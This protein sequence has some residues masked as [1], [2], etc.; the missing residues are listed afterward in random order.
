[1]MMFVSEDSHTQFDYFKNSNNFK[2]QT[3]RPTCRSCKQ[4]R[5]GNTVNFF[6]FF[7]FDDNHRLNAMYSKA[8]SVTLYLYIYI[9]TK[10]KAVK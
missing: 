7:F 10:E 5:N 6:C 3:I 2:A 4:L 9:Y 8:S 1:M